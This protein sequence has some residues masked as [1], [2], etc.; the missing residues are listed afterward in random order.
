MVDVKFI[1]NQLIHGGLTFA[2]RLEDGNFGGIHTCSDFE[3]SRY[4]YRF[5]IEDLIDVIKV[6]SKDYP[7][8]YSMTYNPK[9]Q[10]Y[11]ITTKN[12]ESRERL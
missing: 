1:C 2:Y 7:D 12:R 6:A 10:D 3:R 11:D 5:P 8:T 4:V 9:T